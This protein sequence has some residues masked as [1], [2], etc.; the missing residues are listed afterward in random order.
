MVEKEIKLT[1]NDYKNAL[2]NH[3]CEVVFEKKDG[4][5]RKL[6]CTLDTQFIPVSSQKVLKEYMDQPKHRESPNSVTV[7]DLEKNTWRAFRIESVLVFKKVKETR[8]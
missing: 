4:T 5:L 1:K 6:I 8:P 7:F 2:R 3:I